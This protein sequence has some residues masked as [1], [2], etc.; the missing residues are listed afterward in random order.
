MLNLLLLP[1]VNQLYVQIQFI[2]LWSQTGNNNNFL[3]PKVKN[4]VPQGRTQLEE[5][6]RPV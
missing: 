4:E 3:N 6:W 2:E 1:V 5:T